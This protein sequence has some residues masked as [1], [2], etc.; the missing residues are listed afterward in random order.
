MFYDGTA[1]INDSGLQIRVNASHISGDVVSEIQIYMMT[2]PD[3]GSTYKK[4]QFYKIKSSHPH[5]PKIYDIQVHID[6]KLKALR[7]KNG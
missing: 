1:R 3:S 7:F 4:K 2:V 6:G 5:A